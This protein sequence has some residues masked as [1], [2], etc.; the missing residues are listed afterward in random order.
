[1]VP[2]PVGLASLVV[3]ICFPFSH[4]SEGIPSPI[5]SWAVLQSLQEAVG[6]VSLGLPRGGPG[7]SKYRDFPMFE[8]VGKKLFVQNSAFGFCKFQGESF[9]CQFIKVFV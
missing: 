6:S 7:Y 3:F 5:F 4:L 2:G 9:L 8:F 1:M